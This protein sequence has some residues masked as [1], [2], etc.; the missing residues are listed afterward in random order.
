M[1]PNK[2]FI[3]TVLKGFPQSRQIEKTPII[4]M[5]PSSISPGLKL[6]QMMWRERNLYTDISVVKESLKK[7]H[8]MF[9]TFNK[10]FADGGSSLVKASNSFRQVFNSYVKITP[11]IRT[12]EENIEVLPIDFQ[13]EDSFMEPKS[14]QKPLSSTDIKKIHNIDNDE[15]I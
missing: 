4:L 6:I 7:L 12:I 8:K 5:N 14:N 15:Q 11:E 10:H 3:R 1:Q 2:W 13:D 9:V